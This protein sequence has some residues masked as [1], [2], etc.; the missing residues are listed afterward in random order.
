MPS[1]LLSWIFE[2]VFIYIY[3]SYN[4]T[5][6]TLPCRTYSAVVDYLPPTISI[7]HRLF[8]FVYITECIIYQLIDKGSAGSTSISFTM[9]R[10]PDYNI[11]CQFQ[12]GSPLVLRKTQSLVSCRRANIRYIIYLSVWMIFPIS[13]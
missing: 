1:L 7:F 9:C 10:L 11:R 12:F 3:H 5:L 8:Y 13:I 6:L 4:I 2:I